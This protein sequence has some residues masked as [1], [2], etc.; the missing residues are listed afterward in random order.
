W[1]SRLLPSCEQ[2]RA[3]SSFQKKVAYLDIETTGGMDPLSLTVV[4][5]YDG[6]RLRQFIRGDNLDE[7]PQAIADTQMIVTFFGT[8]FDLPF[9]RRAFRMEFPQLH[10]DLCYLLKRLGHSGGL[11]KVERSLGLHRSKETDGLDGMDAVRLWRE[12]VL[13]DEKSL[14]TLLR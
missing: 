7:F 5:M 10:V 13:G 2:W 1:F 14:E 4:G 9:L 6:I 3:F 8:G 11:K 12:Y